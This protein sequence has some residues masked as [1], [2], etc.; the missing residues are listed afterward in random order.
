MNEPAVVL[1][2]LALALECAGFALWLRAHGANGAVGGWLVGL[3]I[4]AAVAPLLGGAYHALYT[5][6]DT[7][8]ARVLWL[9]ALFA[10]G[11]VALACWSLGAHLVLRASTARIV[12]RLAAVELGLYAVLLLAGWQSFSAAVAV[13]LP[14]VLFLLV[15][16]LRRSVVAALGLAIT[17]GAAVAQQRRLGLPALGLGHNAVYH[18]NQAV[19]FALFFAGSRRWISAPR[20]LTREV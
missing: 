11:V 12:V 8:G 6:L 13:Y 4:A 20:P 19:G 10:V 9:A 14:A 15:A 7:P 5:E 1:T 3:F 16:S 2:D 18:L 17:L